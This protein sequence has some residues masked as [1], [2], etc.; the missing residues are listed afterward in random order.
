MVDPV[1]AI[2]GAI[3]SGV[4]AAAAPV[5][6]GI[7]SLGAGLG[8]ALG[9][10]GAAGAAGT[11]FSAAELAGAVSPVIVGPA[12]AGGLSSAAAAALGAGALGAGA[13]G[14]SGA[15]G[16]DAASYLGSGAA[17]GGGNTV[18]EVTVVGQP[19][20]PGA[21]TGPTDI[22]PPPIVLPPPPPS[23][24]G[25]LDTTQPNLKIPQGQNQFAKDATKYAENKLL[26]SVMQ[27]ALGLNSTPS[28]G[29][30]NTSFSGSPGTS[31]G[32]PPVQSTTPA[33]QGPGVTGASVGTPF[34]GGGS[35]PG[36]GI[37]GGLAISGSTAPNIYPWV[38]SQ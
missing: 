3:I 12:A 7:G 35:G 27:Q 36:G 16:G 6:G 2:I 29:N 8:S 21:I 19:N 18:D 13:A 23:L 22:L 5:I 11:G 26:S 33:T 25:A 34:A 31:D 32:I 1:T 38:P 10:A 9:G 14:L 37:P 4:E 30:V 15:F 28:G 17:G 24:L 20:T